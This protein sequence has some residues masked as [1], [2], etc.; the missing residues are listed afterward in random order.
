MALV[1]AR[2][3]G[4][5]FSLDPL[6][7][8]AKRRARRRRWL[9][10]L[11]LVVAVA[12]ATAGLELRSGSDSGLAAVGP[13]PVIHIVTESPPVSVYLNLKTGRA[14]R[15]TLR[16]ESWSDR[17]SGRSQ[18][19][20]TQGGRVTFDQL[21]TYHYPAD[22][23]AAAV[24]NFYV[25]VA[26]GLRTALRA[27][28]AELV[29]R[30]TFNGHR[31]DWLRV[32][33]TALPSWRHG[34]PWW[35]AS[36]A[37]GVDAQTYKPILIRWPGGKHSSYT[38]ILAA[39][40]IA[41]DPADF[42]RRGPKHPRLS[43][44]QMASGFAFGSASPSAPTSTVVR[45]PWLTAGA[46]VAGLKL[47]AVRPFT[48]RPSKHHFAYG[49][50][51][52]KAIHGLELVYGPPSQSTSPILPRLINL[53]GPQWQPRATTRLTTIYEVPQAARV[54]PWSSVPADS[55]QVQTGLATSGK[56]VVPTLRV[57][58]LKKR[59]LYITIRTPQSQQT[60]LQIARSL[61]TGPR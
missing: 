14:T 9:G 18:S 21:G 6:I 20:V 58:Y 22:S 44:Q 52:P 35:Q 49:A 13:R 16:N 34:Q 46:T 54:P 25:T 50:P 4:W 24:T 48:I 59:G 32:R 31:I 61:H 1:L 33:Q 11:V 15:E 26:M 27:G 55:V 38:R 8:E 56:H 17:R 10:V 60:A 29:G 36:E 37:V 3:P 45:G 19:I 5:P 42:K 51:N 23:E 2:V 43:G 53:Y 57:G 7:A 12:A 39:D 28:K 47:R 30:G 41:Y 40:A